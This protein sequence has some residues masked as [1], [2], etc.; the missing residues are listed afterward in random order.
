M[1]SSDG[2]HVVRQQNIAPTIFR[3]ADSGR[4]AS[5]H[6]DNQA[7]ARCSVQGSKVERNSFGMWPAYGNVT[8][9][10]R[11]CISWNC[12]ADYLDGGY[13]PIGGSK[14]IAEHT[15]ETIDLYGGMCFG[16]PC[17]SEILVRK[18]R[19]VGVRVQHKGKT[20]DFH[21]PIIISNAGAFTTFSKLC[22][23][24]ISLE[25]SVQN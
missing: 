20:I 24:R 19:A 14:Q 15:A 10:E 17:V 9:R 22:S 5:S 6:D 25:M 12:H 21:A 3:Y 11:F 8:A 16:Q 7:N 2:Y 23:T 13:Y 4:T 1:L 18:N